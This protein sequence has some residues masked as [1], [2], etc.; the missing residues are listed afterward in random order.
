MIV[1]EKSH[2]ANNFIK[3]NEMHSS[4]VAIY[5]KTAYVSFEWSEV[6]RWEKLHQTILNMNHII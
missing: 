2:K 4:S 5:K 6:C 3:I 1:V